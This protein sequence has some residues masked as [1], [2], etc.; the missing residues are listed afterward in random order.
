MHNHRLQRVA[1]A[2]DAAARKNGI[3][4]VRHTAT[5]TTAATAGRVIVAIVGYGASMWQLTDALLDGGGRV[6]RQC[7]SVIAAIQ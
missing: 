3:K 7:A 4:R 2:A 5:V 1:A 6:D